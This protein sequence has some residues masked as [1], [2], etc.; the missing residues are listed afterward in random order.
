M[1]RVINA[2]RTF[3]WA[4]Q[5]CKITDVSLVEQEL[6]D[7]LHDL[8]SWTNE[9]FDCEANLEYYKAQA[10]TETQDIPK[11]EPNEDNVYLDLNDLPS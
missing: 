1:I 4:V 3:L 8:D 11:N 2:S 10:R 5:H 9:R 6:K 7:A